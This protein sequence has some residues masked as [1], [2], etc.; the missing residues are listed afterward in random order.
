VNRFFCAAA[1][2]ERHEPGFATAS[3]VDRWLLVEAPGAWGPRALP[4]SRSLDDDL[5]LPLQQKAKRLHARTLLIRR[6]GRSLP[7]E[8]RWVFAADSRAGSEALLA[9]HVTDAELADLHLPFDGP[10]DD[11]ERATTLVGVCTHG[12]HD[13]CCATHGRAVAA[14]LGAAH[15]EIT[16]EISHLGGDRF[17]ANALVLPGG[18]YLGQVPADSAVEVIDRLLRGERPDPYY[19]GRS[20]WPPVVQAAL[21]FVAIELGETRIE[22]LQPGPVTILDRGRWRVE[23]HPSG[24]GSR[25]VVV[26]LGQRQGPESSLLTCRALSELPV[27]SWYLVGIER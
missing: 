15:P 2:R 5:L 22:A 7:D 24:G 17:A 8:R 25:A 9:R 13:A 1:A 6:P 11:W 14:A 26:E 12:R 10:S 27:P 16:W 20:C 18:H 4:Q 19:R 3:R 21:T 23:V